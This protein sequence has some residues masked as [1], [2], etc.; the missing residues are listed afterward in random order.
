M[1]ALDAAG[2]NLKVLSNRHS[3]RSLYADFRGGHVIDWSASDK[4]SLLMSRSY[5]PENNTGT[6]ILN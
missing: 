6:N 4:G 1:I 2:G 5:V 3:A